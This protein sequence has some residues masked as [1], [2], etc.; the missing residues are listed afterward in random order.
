MEHKI[1]QISLIKISLLQQREGEEE[2][3]AEEKAEEEEQIVKATREKE[4]RKKVICSK[5]SALCN[6]QPRPLQTAPSQIEHDIIEVRMPWVP[7]ATSVIWYKLMMARPDIRIIRELIRRCSLIWGIEVHIS[8]CSSEL[9]CIT[10]SADNRIGLLLGCYRSKS[11]VDIESR[12]QI[13]SHTST[14]QIGI[15]RWGANRKTA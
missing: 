13:R 1:I 2:E 5:Q 11:L 3:A 8:Q 14:H 6:H 10:S 4:T 12:S 9:V 15:L 7:S